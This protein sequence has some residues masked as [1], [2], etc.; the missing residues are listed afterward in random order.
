MTSEREAGG[1][2]PSATPSTGTTPLP[3][4]TA[5]SASVT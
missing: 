2:L 4:A 5:V 1:H 3:S